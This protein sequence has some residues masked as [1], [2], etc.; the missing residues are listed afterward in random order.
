M[1]SRGPWSIVSGSVIL[2]II[3]LLQLLALIVP[4]YLNSWIY[5]KCGQ[6]DKNTI[7]QYNTQEISAI[8]DMHH[9]LY[10]NSNNVNILQIL[11]IKK[12]KK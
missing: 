9:N 10:K 2:F 11:Q 3:E 6:C 1:V 12:S 8:H 7:S 4:S 5:C